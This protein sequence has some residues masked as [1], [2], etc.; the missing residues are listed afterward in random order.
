MSAPAAVLLRETRETTLIATLNRPERRNAL[1]IELVAA[2]RALV[3]ELKE[4]GPVRALI[5]TG[6]GQRAFCA[7]ADLKER[8]G[9][10]DDQVRAFLD[11]LQA[12]T[13]GLE[14]LP[15]PVIA[16]INGHALGGGLELALGCDL[17]I[18]AENASL[19]LPETRLGII[20]GAG[21]TA[22]LPRLIGVAKARELIYT[23]RRVNA[24]EALA[25]GLV[26]A[27][28]PAEDLR[29]VACDLADEIAQAAPLAIARAKQSIT[30]GLDGGLSHALRL[31]R[32]R[33]ETLLPTEDRVEALRA[34]AEGRPPVFRGR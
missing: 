11:T 5:L 10:D 7:G 12:L 18:C 30:G 31:E 13:T 16:A 23:G 25:L 29:G 27:T 14:A 3:E 19:G 26:N 34:F 28:V 32:D 4:P 1:S 24:D 20:P 9:M 33:Y 21:G 2:L 17:R 6:A 15:I 22:R 8:E